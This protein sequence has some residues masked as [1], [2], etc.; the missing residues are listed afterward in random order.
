MQTEIENSYKEYESTIDFSNQTN[1][2]DFTAGFKACAKKSI[3][4]EKLIDRQLDR[5]GLTKREYFAAMAMQGL[6][7]SDTQLIAPDVTIESISV[8]M[9]DALIAELNKE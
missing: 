8:Q 6:L 1:K 3:S 7:A 5:Q 9:A 4:K 2:R